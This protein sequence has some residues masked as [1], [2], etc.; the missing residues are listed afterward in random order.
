MPGTADPQ[1]LLADPSSATWDLQP[2]MAVVEFVVQKDSVE[3]T[4]R[5]QGR[6]AKEACDQE[7]RR[8][9]GQHMAMVADIAGLAVSDPLSEACGLAASLLHLDEDVCLDVQPWP[10][11]LRLDQAIS[12]E[13]VL[14]AP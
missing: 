10:P 1:D 6:V 9:A 7:P 4:E 2:H 11:A 14:E 3:M 5:N 12:E 13:Q 8:G